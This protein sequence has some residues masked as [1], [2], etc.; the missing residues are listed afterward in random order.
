MFYRSGHGILRMF[1][2]HVQALVR[3]A[4][5][6]GPNGP[7]SINHF[8]V[9]YF[10]A[11]IFLV[12]PCQHLVDLQHHHR[13]APESKHHHIWYRDSSKALNMIFFR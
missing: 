13:S 10:L 5:Y 8:A 3:N 6:H 1:F 7:N 4:S 12:R 9:Q 2:L 11:N